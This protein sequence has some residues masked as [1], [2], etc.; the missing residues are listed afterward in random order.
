MASAGLFERLFLPERAKRVAILC[1]HREITY[2][3]CGLRRSVVEVLSSACAPEI[4]RHSVADS[5][6]HRDVCGC[7]LC[8]RGGGADHL[9]LGREE[10]PF[11]RIARA[12]A[13]IVEAQA[14]TL[15]EHSRC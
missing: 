15:F 12:C 11:S 14:V 6:D 8:R 13:A 7:H 5:P 10:Q 9:A 3:S 2:E 1:E 4:S